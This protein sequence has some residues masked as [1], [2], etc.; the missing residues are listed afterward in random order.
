MSARADY[1]FTPWVMLPPTYIFVP[2]LYDPEECS[3]PCK[4]TKD[5]ALSVKQ[6]A[7]DSK[8]LLKLYDW[9]YESIEQAFIA[10]Y[11]T[12]EAT[13]AATGE[14]QT[15]S[16]LSKTAPEITMSEQTK[17]MQRSF[18]VGPECG[19]SPIG[20]VF[21]KA[22]ENLALY[23]GLMEAESRNF[24]RGMTEDLGNADLWLAG[25]AMDT[26]FDFSSL[27]LEDE[28]K[29]HPRRAAMVMAGYMKNPRPENLNPEKLSDARYI[30]REA[31]LS[32]YRSIMDES[33][34][35]AIAVREEVVPYKLIRKWIE[36]WYAFAENAGEIQEEEGTSDGGAGSGSGYA[37]NKA[38]LVMARNCKTVMDFGCTRE[39]AGK[40]N[41]K[42]TSWT[43][44]PQRAKCWESV[45]KHSAKHGVD[46][47]Y[48]AALLG[49][50]SSGCN[51]AYANRKN[52]YGSSALGV[53]QTLRDTQNNDIAKN[54]PDLRVTCP[55]GVVDESCDPRLDVDKSVESMIIYFKQILNDNRVKNDMFRAVMAYHD[56]AGGMNFFGK[57]GY[58]E[59]N[60]DK[61]RNGISRY[62]EGVEYPAK[63]ICIPGTALVE[64]V[65][66]K[67]VENQNLPSQTPNIEPEDDGQPVL[68]PV[69]PDEEPMKTTPHVASEAE[70]RRYVNAMPLYNDLDMLSLEETYNILG[71]FF[72]SDPFQKAVGSM[73]SGGVAAMTMPIKVMN[74]RLLNKIRED[75]LLRNLLLVLK[76]IPGYNAMN[77]QATL[78]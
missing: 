16:E 25:I 51:E 31:A 23:T 3:D 37:L 19:N 69:G 18:S 72:M 56:G 78:N 60:N 7:K 20:Y 48:I 34:R 46:A 30:A 32:I 11:R 62:C 13:T 52:G 75:Y 26:S 12:M 15:R 70:F 35:R 21:A 54:R 71:Q 17:S 28:E 50:E 8:G 58:Y 5:S 38:P 44:L 64:G 76:N 41:P 55:P 59:K 29:I 61:I 22:D 63:I 4:Y 14:A 53:G 6:L 66:L 33:W 1:K 67:R 40:P 42:Y 45:K 10:A 27:V 73:D 65:T 39:M 74:Y 43:K 24:A 68:P 57:H 9:A 47:D 2:L 49:A 77:N 36:Q